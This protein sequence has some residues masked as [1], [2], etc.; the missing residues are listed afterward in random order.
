MISFQEQKFE[1]FSIYYHC[2]DKGNFFIESST[3]KNLWFLLK[4]A[5]ISPFS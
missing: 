2:I 4:S 3:I 1:E 5:I